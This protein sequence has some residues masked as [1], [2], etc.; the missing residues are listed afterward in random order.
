MLVDVLLAEMLLSTIHSMDLAVRMKSRI[1][2]KYLSKAIFCVEHPDYALWL[3]TIFNAQSY[4]KKLRQ[5]GADDAEI[6]LASKD[7]ADQKERFSAVD[8]YS[9]PRTV[10]DMMREQTGRNGTFTNEEYVWQYA[11]PSSLIHGDPEG[12]RW[13]M[14][15]DATG[16]TQTTLSLNDKLLNALMV[17]AGANVLAFC[18]LF[19]EKFKPDD[20]VLAT[21]SAEFHRIFN[22]LAL[23]HAYGRP[24]EGLRIVR[25]QLAT[26]D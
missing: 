20:K 13:L 22:I 4:L 25:E 9:E 8:H 23:K 14:S 15:Y 26:G 21:K 17:D 6:A 3:S 10:A 16:M 11:A 2:T 19:I 12:M 7:L 18:D 1:L 5:G 24:E